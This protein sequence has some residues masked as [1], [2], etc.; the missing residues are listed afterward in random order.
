MIKKGQITRFINN[1][2]AK[3]ISSLENEQ[4]DV[5]QVLREANKEKYAE[6]IAD[7]NNKIAGLFTQ[8]R[9]VNNKSI[10]E[11]SLRDYWGNPFMRAISDLND[12]KSDINGFDYEY[13][14]SEC[15]VITNKYNQM[16][17]EVR[18]EYNTLRANLRNKS[19]AKCKEELEALGFDVSTIVDEAL[20][21]TET[22]IAVQVDTS[23]LFITKGDN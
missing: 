23:K 3:K 11:G 7:I 12:L 1:A 4:R 21:C 10:E 22:A 19:G 20:T 9:N 6:E 18:R 13:A 5:V 15:A 2:E 8:L 17:Y 16:I 14:H